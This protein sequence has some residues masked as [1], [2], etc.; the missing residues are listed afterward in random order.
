MALPD[1]K[2]IVSSLGTVLPGIKKSVLIFII[3]LW[4]LEEKFV[5]QQR[6]KLI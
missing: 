4:R 1:I 3:V 6:S 2:N 5:G